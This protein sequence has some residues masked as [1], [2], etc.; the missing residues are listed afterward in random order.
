MEYNTGVCVV[1]YVDNKQSIVQC[2]GAC[3]VYRGGGKE[4]N[5]RDSTGQSHIGGIDYIAYVEDI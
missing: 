4:C 3:M 2:S 5:A 1:K